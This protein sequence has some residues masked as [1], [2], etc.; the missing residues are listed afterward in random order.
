[1]RRGRKVLLIKVAGLLV[2]VWLTLMGFSLILGGTDVAM[3]V[4]GVLTL[5]AA[6]AGGLWLYSHWNAPTG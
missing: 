4:I 1:M 6:I 2:V 3:V 5:A